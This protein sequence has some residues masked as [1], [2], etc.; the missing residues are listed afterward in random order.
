MSALNLETSDLFTPIVPSMIGGVIFVLLMAYWLGKKN[1]NESV[2][3]R[4]IKA[5]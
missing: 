2:L 5:L 1:E 4:S 3:W